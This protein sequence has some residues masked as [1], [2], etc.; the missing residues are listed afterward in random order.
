MS[1]EQS[2]TAYPDLLSEV[3]C[4]VCFFAAL[5]LLLAACVGHNGKFLA[6]ILDSLHVH[7]ILAAATGDSHP[8]ILVAYRWRLDPLLGW[9]R[10]PIQDKSL[11]RMAISLDSEILSARWIRTSS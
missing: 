4:A 6:S 5:P 3:R 7:T 11:G 1:V 8:G 2:L 10:D 9:F